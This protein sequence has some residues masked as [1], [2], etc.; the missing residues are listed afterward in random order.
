MP[1]KA[2]VEFHGAADHLSIGGA[3][4]GPALLNDWGE[5]QLSASRLPAGSH[6]VVAG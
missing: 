6:A 4:V 2:P 3:S 5:A 1:R